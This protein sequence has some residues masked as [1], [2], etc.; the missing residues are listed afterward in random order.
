MRII[1]TK[2]VL[3]P[4]NAINLY[5]GCTHGCIY[6]DSRSTVYGIGP[7][8]DIGVKEDA[9]NK[10]RDELSRKKTKGMIYTGS[11][12]DPYIPLEQ[13]LR[14]TEGMLKAIYDFGFGVSILTKSDLALRDIDLIDQINKRNCAVVCYTLTTYDEELCNLL[15]PNVASTKRRLECLKEF[16]SR[17]ITTGVWMG[18]ILPFIND[19]EEN[20]RNLVKACSEAGVTFIIQFGMG[21]T[22]RE[23]NREYFY[24]QL[25]R[26]FPK[27]K[28]VY[29]M[30]YGNRYECKSPKSAYLT[31]IF[32]DECNKYGIKINTFDYEKHYKKQNIIDQLR[33]FDES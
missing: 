18:P 28:Q 14:L 7:F 32:V 30:K 23:G 11:M 33:L 3:L 24:E 8:E 10:L 26:L 21:L 17:N 6:C 15:E 13:E 31:K 22:L 20:I 16:A 12:C 5:R 25:D 2:K 1:P 9:M 19:T 4:N 29:Q 27:L